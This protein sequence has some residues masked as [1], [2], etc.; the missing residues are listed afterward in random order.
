VSR[1][2]DSSATGQGPLR[3][4]GGGY[5]STPPDPAATGRGAWG[6]SWQVGL[7][8]AAWGYL[9]CLHWDNDGLWFQG[10]APRHAMNGLFWRDLLR[11]PPTDPYRY[12]L[13]YYARYPAI[14]PNL[15]PPGFYLLEA[16]SF[17]LFGPSPHAAKG[18]VLGCA[19]VAALYLT[20][21]L[22]RWVAPTTGGAAALLL[23]SPGLTAW[24]H[25]VMLNV[26]GLAFGLAALYHARRAL[27]S[28]DGPRYPRHLYLAAALAVLGILT[29]P[30][31]GVVVFVGLAWAAE[32]GR[33]KLLARPKTLLL[34]VSCAVLLLPWAYVTYRWAPQQ[35]RQAEP[36]ALGLSDPWGWGY[37]PRHATELFDPPLLALA[38]LGVAGGLAQ[39]RWR[40]ET[41]LLLLWVGV[42]FVTFSLIRSKEA[43][44]LLLIGPPA[45]AASALAMLGVS[46]GV[47][48][49]VPKMRRCLVFP[50]LLGALVVGQ[51]ERARHRGIPS[52]G[53]F[54]PVAEF[55]QRMAPA[56]P[57]LYDGA[58]DGV[59]VFHLRAGD[60]AYQQQV[61]L[62]ANLLR[63]LPREELSD[64]EVERVLLDSGCRWLVIEFGD[65]SEGPASARALRRVLTR[66]TMEQVR[67]FPIHRHGAQRVGV[68]R[69][70][71]PARRAGA[72]GVPVAV[73]GGIGSARMEPLRR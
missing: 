9:C 33:W 46:A 58:H 39:R 14:N 59:F 31:T 28:A 3:P 73:P 70:R 22:R 51:V 20:A 30:T 66:D 2:G 52:V 25:A 72:E 67:C 7:V 48:A 23:L 29:Y 55:V 6:L 13:A 15:Y 50:L 60:S 5:T 44:Y 42:C 53:E 57:V 41:A 45:I 27:E 54:R 19:L 8:L 32:L 34:A 64:D 36:L 61:V 68:Y 49:V 63:A 71:A 21:W 62:G 16:L 43:R 47:E 17:A 24:A 11:A 18:L 10:D 35:L 4:P 65:L 26:P 56:E 1:T 12:A 40:R 37:Y 69:L 38:G